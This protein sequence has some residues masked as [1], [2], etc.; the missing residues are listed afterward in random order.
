MFYTSNEI[1]GVVMESDARR[2]VY[3]GRRTCSIQVME[4]RGL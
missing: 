4:S 2:I 1:K 3:E